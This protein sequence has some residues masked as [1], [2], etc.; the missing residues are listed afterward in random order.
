[1]EDALSVSDVRA[2]VVLGA[3]AEAF[4]P[5]LDGLPVTFVK[6]ME[7]STGTGSSVSKC[8]EAALVAN[9]ET[10]A[11]IFLLCAGGPPMVF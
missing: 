1:M 3:F 4:R 9:P 6:D 2:V 11:A 5:V 8:L 7:W 10:A